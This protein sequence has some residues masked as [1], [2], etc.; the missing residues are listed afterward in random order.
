MAPVIYPLF[1]ELIASGCR[2]LQFP[3]I[4]L[5]GPL[6]E[7]LRPTD[8]AEPPRRQA[9]RLAGVPIA[10]GRRWPSSPGRPAA[11][12]ARRA[13]SADQP[14]GADGERGDG[15]DAEDHDPGAAWH[16]R[17][18]C[19]LVGVRALGPAPPPLVLQLH[20]RP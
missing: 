14:A 18:A 5:I 19:Q 2:S 12:P 9:E 10:D 8:R 20:D 13:R 17:E 7:Q 16:P 4:P 15:D 3:L 11:P 6:V 1:R